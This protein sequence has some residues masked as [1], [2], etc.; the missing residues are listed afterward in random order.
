MLR[1]AAGMA[2]SVQGDVRDLI[3]TIVEHIQYDASCGKVLVQL[4]RRHNLTR[5]TQP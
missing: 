5:G 2:V 3:A 4:R 1:Y